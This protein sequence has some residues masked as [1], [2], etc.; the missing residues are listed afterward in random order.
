MEVLQ[1]SELIKTFILDPLMFIFNPRE[2]SRIKINYLSTQYGDKAI[3]S[4]WENVGRDLQKALHSYER[5][6]QCDQIKI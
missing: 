6:M 2:S 1:L 5:E 3:Q 4:D